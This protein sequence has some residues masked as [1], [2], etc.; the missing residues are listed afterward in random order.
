VSQFGTD[1]PF[2]AVLHQAIVE[3]AQRS[4]PLLQ[5]DQLLAGG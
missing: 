4:A 3:A 1:I 2:R 5:R